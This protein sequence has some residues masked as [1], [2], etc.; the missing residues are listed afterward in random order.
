MPAPGSTLNTWAIV[1]ARTLEARG[2]DSAELFRQAGMDPAILGDPNGRYS[3][4]QMAR[5]WRLAV[6]ATGDRCL[7]IHAAEYVQPATFHNLGLALLASVTLEDALVRAARYSRIV[8]NAADVT[9]DETREGIRQTL[10]FRR[11]MPQVDEDIDLFMAASRKM[12]DLLTGRQIKPRQIRLRRRATPEMAA[13]FER[14]FGVPVEFG[15]GENSLMVGLEDARRPLPMGNAV[16][17]GQTDRIMLEQIARSD[18]ASIAERVRAELIARLPSGE[19]GR[20]DLA[21]VLAMSEKTLQR[22]LK[23]ER[24]TYQHLLDETRRELAEEYLRDGG[25]SVCEVTFRLGFSDQSSFT[26]AF[27]R[28]TGVAPREFRARPGPPHL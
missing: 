2:I 4:A 14:F 16:L 20:A 7:G 25:L 9:V 27:K 15:A 24:T 26:R 22:R 6:Q 17:A 19:P 18:D 11:G 21:R 3:V 23:D 5:L 10:T 12:G 1:V 13:E 28:W 8:S